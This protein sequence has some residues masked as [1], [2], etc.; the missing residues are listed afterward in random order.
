MAFRPE[1]EVRDPNG[2]IRLTDQ[3]MGLVTFNRR[4]RQLAM[5]DLVYPGAVHTKHSLTLHTAHRISP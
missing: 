1:Y 5:A 4:I 2:L 3:E